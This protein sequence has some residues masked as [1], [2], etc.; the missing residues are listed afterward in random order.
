M[1]QDYY[2]VLGVDKSAS[3]DEIKRA[4]R[5]QAKKY[6]PDANPDD[7]QAEE[8]FKQVNEA[9]DVL[10]DEKKRQQYDAFGKGFAN[11]QGA[12][13]GGSGP[14]GGNA[15]YVDVDFENIADIFNS[16]MGG[17]G[18]FSG[19]TGPRTGGVGGFR[20]RRAVRGDD[21]EHPVEISLREAYDGT[22]R[23]LT[24][25]GRQLKVKIP[26]GARTGTKV[27]L[28]GEGGRGANGGPAGDLLLVVQ[29]QPDHTFERDGDDLYA[30]VNVDFLTAALGGTVTMPT[31]TGSVSLKIPAGTQS[32]KKIRLKGKGMPVLRGKGRYG[33]LYARV[34]IT[35]PEHL[36]PAQRELL[37]QFRTSKS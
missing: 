3:Q 20:Q 22:E 23:L 32:G 29:V 4:Y 2:S 10:G 27:R 12:P 17:S 9:Y 16:F 28:S 18:G 1:A 19:T 11:F 14:Y 31:M 34:M 15:Q 35:V 36:T 30:D 5:K 26:A 6:H 24:V 13:G 7:P 33:N 21:Y 25:D 37:E 8:R